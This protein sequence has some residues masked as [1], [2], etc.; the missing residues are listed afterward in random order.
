MIALSI[1][2]P[3]AWLI[4]NGAKDIE[5]RDWKT[6]FRGRVLLHVGKVMTRSEYE[7]GLNHLLFYGGPHIDLPPMDQLVRGGVV[8]AVD[9]V[10]C[11][12][13]SESPWFFGPFGFVLRN[14]TPMPFMPW[15][16][17][18]GFFNVPESE[19]PC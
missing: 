4:L 8:G 2:Q 19:W 17:K 11:V 13:H 18:L 6:N 15:K 16:G 9:I 12:E 5:N 14:P 3:W 1:R 10:D 7:D